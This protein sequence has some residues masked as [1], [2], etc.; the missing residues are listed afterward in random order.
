VASIV[1]SP[2]EAPPRSL[3]DINIDRAFRGAAI[4]LRLPDF[5]I[6]SS[7]TRDAPA[8]HPG[9][10]LSPMNH[11]EFRPLRSSV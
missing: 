2:D 8:L 10:S 1:R 7:T 4:V 5:A 3:S 6:N 11:R 9:Y